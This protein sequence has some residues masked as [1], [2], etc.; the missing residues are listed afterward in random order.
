MDENDE[1]PE[2]AAPRGRKR[3]E[4]KQRKPMEITEEALDRVALSY[5]DRYDA[6]ASKLRRVLKERVY[7]ALRDVSDRNEA[8]ASSELGAELIENM[9]ERFARSGLVDDARFAKNAVYGFRSRGLST[10]AIQMKL[11]TQGVPDEIVDEVL[12]ES[13][14]EHNELD[15]ARNLVRRRKLGLHRPEEKREAYRDKD[16]GVL[17][18][19]G[20]SFELAR[21]A[22]LEPERD[23]E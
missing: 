17:A 4:R 9:L 10:R 3:K 11:R 6:T 2:R 19:A 1:S 7:K 20:F 14:G 15:S 5:L 13:C 16:L 21:Q 23:Y 22:L 8:M 12:E 18:R